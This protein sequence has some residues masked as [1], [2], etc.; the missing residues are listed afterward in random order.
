MPSIVSTSR[1]SASRPSMRQE[2]IE[3]PS[4]STAQVDRKSTRLNSSHANIYSLSLH[5]ALPISS[6]ILLRQEGSRACSS[7]IALRQGLRKSPAK[8]EDLPQLPC[9]RLSQPLGLLHRG[10]A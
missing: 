2:R 3:R 5:D 9:L 4:T 1:P 8:D 6:I 10:Q 7:R